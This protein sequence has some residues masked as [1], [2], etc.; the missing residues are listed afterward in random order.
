MADETAV[1]VAELS[2][3]VGRIEDDTR[4]SSSYTHVMLEDLITRVSKLETAAARFETNLIHVNGSGDTTNKQLRDI[5]NRMR[6]LERLA[7][8][9]TG[10]FLAFTGVAG[11]FGWKFIQFVILKGG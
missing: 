8:I 3:R 4:R 11:F 5:E 9:S 10:A 7:Y 2:V 6:S 1:K